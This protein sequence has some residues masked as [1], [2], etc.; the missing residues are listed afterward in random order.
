MPACREKNLNLKHRKQE[1]TGLIIQNTSAV[2]DPELLETIKNY[3]SSLEN[4]TVVITKS[5]D[6]ACMYAYSNYLS[7]RKLA[8][9]QSFMYNE[10]MY[11]YQFICKKDIFDE[12]N[13]AKI[14]ND[15][16]IDCEQFQINSTFFYE[17]NLWN[18]SKEN[19]TWVFEDRKLSLT[20]DE[21]NRNYDDPELPTIGF[22]LSED[23]ENKTGFKWC[24]GTQVKPQGIYWAADQQEF[25]LFHGSSTFN[26]QFLCI[27]NE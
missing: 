6:D 11:N 8:Q 24:T 21:L 3:E 23:L 27:S 22:E 18:R 5:S 17:Y 2:E 12:F 16:K 19:I 4:N 20:A 13:R 7:N 10:K 9:E 14:I 1:I 25:V 26:R 15:Y